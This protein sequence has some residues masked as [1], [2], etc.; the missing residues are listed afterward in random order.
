MGGNTSDNVCID[1]HNWGN[2][3][4]ISQISLNV[5]LHVHVHVYVFLITHY[6]NMMRNVHDVIEVPHAIFEVL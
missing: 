6:R 1:L 5:Y 2:S 4:Y 3:I